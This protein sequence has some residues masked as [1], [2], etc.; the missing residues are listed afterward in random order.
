MI[1]LL[2]SYFPGPCSGDKRP[3]NKERGLNTVM[4]VQNSAGSQSII[5][6]YVVY[7]QDP[8]A[9][10]LLGKWICNGTESS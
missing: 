2:Y 10:G 8:L 7:W 9:R 5:L 1:L 3:P 4:V 6:G